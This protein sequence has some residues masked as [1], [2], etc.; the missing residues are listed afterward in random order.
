ML[1]FGEERESSGEGPRQSPQKFTRKRSGAKFAAYELKRGTVRFLYLALFALG[2]WPVARAWYAN[3][4]TSLLHALNWVWAAWLMWGIALVAGEPSAAGLEPGRFLA[5]CMTG[6]AGVAVLGARQPHAGAWNFVVLGL[7]CVL[8]LPLLENRVLGTTSLG[9][10]RV[11]FIGSTVAVPL[12]NYLPTRFGAAAFVLALACSGELTLFFV[13]DA[14]VIMRLAPISHM[15]LLS[16]PWLAFG[17]EKRRARPIAQF[18]LLWV[19]FRDRWGL[20]WAQRVREQFNRSAA[21][22][23]WPVH[24]YWQGLALLQTDLPAEQTQ[25]EMIHTLRRLLKRFVATD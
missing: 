24:L 3:R 7:V 9:L 6:A 15:L 14:D 10:L 25:D 16:V 17:C 8:L 23:G 4:Q 5:L 12:L 18:D 11:A 13:D 1:G 19:E 2:S 22:A 21:H 20:F